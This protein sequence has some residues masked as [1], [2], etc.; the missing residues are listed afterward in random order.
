M[1][2]RYF[3]A[4]P[5]EEIGTALQGKVTDYYEKLFQSAKYNYWHKSYTAY[6]GGNDNLS[7]P[8]LKRV[9]ERGEVTKITV[10][11]LRNLMQNLLV[12]VTSERP[13]L[14]LRAVNSDYRSLAQTI[15]GEG[16]IEYYLREKKLGKKWTRAIEKALIFDTSYIIMEWDTSEGSD[17]GV[18]PTTGESVKEGDILY[19]D[20]TPL[21]V[22][23]DQ[24]REAEVKDWYIYRRRVNKFDLA[25]RFPEQAARIIATNN[26]VEQTIG[27]GSGTLWHAPVEH[28]NDD[29]YLWTFL[30]AKTP[31]VKDGR[32]TTFLGGDLVLLD[33]PLP[34]K[35]LPV[36]R[37]SPSDWMER[38]DGYTPSY[39]VVPIQEATNELAT[40]VLSNNMTFA[41][42]NITGPKAADI[43]VEQLAGGLNYIGVDPKSG[44]KIEALQLTASPP[45]TYNFLALL[46]KW[47][48]GATGLNSVARGNPEGSLKGASGSAMALLAAQAIKFSMGLQMSANDLLESVALGTIE[49]LQTFAKTKRMATIAGKNNRS[50][51]KQF[52]K[53][54]VAQINRVICQQTS[55]LSKTT[56][57]RL[58]MARD[59]LG[60][61]KINTPEEY[62]QVVTTGTLQPLIESDQ[63]G[64]MMIR[65][66]NEALRE[67]RPIRAIL[68]DRHDLHIREHTVVTNDPELRT[69][70]IGDPAAQAV[71]DAALAHAQEHIDLWQNMDPAL[72]QLLGIPPAPPPPGMAPP[73]APGQQPPLPGDAPAAEVMATPEAVAGNQAPDSPRMPTNPLTGEQVNPIPGGM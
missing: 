37:C 72:A 30:H 59:L 53:D 45:E 70:A 49:F 54:D 62:M 47:G 48:E 26:V 17:Y 28:S 39:D 20:L 71:V 64:L 40:R 5:V 9:G 3:A 6:Y 55:A 60:A 8:G 29:V 41:M 52:T 2:N 73:A 65:S 51:M 66:E 68:T 14:E 44:G 57:G 69:M 15:L 43:N 18:D 23:S 12:M 67:G 35:T 7:G 36:Y 63:S 27:A 22:V 31:A 42:Q 61:Q 32:L 4:L 1:E 38:A 25:A 11:L 21:H 19:R 34:Y 10:N 33:S 50:Y 16:I 56:S 24:E 13:A 46:E 58:E